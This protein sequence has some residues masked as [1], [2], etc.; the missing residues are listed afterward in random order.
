MARAPTLIA[1]ALIGAMSFLATGCGDDAPRP[2]RRAMS[3]EDRAEVDAFWSSFRAGDDAV[4]A[5]RYAEAIELLENAVSLRPGHEASL[6]QLAT[7]R[8]AIGEPDRALEALAE[9]LVH[10]PRCARA[11]SRIGALLSDPGHPELADLAAAIDH[12]ILARDLNREDSGPAFQLGRARLLAGELD[13]A[14]PLLEAASRQDSRGVLVARVL[15]QALV[16]AGRE[17]EAVAALERV[18]AARMKAIAPKG[19][20][21]EGQTAA[22]RGAPRVDDPTLLPALDDLRRL[23]AG[24][25]GAGSAAAEVLDALEPAWPRW[26]PHAMAIS[27][28]GLPPGSRRARRGDAPLSIE[29]DLDGDGAPERIEIAPVSWPAAL[30]ARLGAPPAGCELRILDAITREPRDSRW[31]RDGES[32][33][34]GLPARCLETGDLDG[35]G[36]IDIFIGCGSDDPFE[37]H[38]D[39]VLLQT[40]PGRFETR[41]FAPG[42]REERGTRRVIREGPR[43]ML[44][45]GSAFPAAAGAAPLRI[46]G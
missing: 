16:A 42:E 18:I 13:A 15:A 28:E 29:A 41:L 11:H 36:R 33:P 19:M 9:I 26:R 17:E 25:P 44:D 5:E 22:D 31:F 7:A 6:Q 10:D 20:T 24:S 8:I 45:R 34:A 21:A 38:A 37:V 43:W 30:A 14:L 35:D 3:S 27:T 12:F 2:P 39:V 32:P 40:A 23:R 1:V 4:R 46:G